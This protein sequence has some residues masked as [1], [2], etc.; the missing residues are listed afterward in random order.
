MDACTRHTK[1]WY[2]ALDKVNG[3][4]ENI[5]EKSPQLA[6]YARWDSAGNFY[7]DEGYYKEIELLEQRE[8][9]LRLAT[10]VRTEDQL[11]HNASMNGFTNEELKQIKFL[12]D[13][14]T[15]NGI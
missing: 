6:K 14:I 12:A 9:A 13:S 2:E 10:N 8:K 15:S 5:L 11:K 3:A 7:W 1:E 4:V